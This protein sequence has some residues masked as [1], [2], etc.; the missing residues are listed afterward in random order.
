[1]HNLSSLHL[2]V[3]TA[4]SY[5]HAVAALL[6]ITPSVNNGT[7]G[8]LYPLLQPEVASKLPPGTYVCFY[9]L[10]DVCCVSCFCVHAVIA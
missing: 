4:G 9:V 1:M 10:Y 2:L 3:P 8:S 6:G 7:F 5:S